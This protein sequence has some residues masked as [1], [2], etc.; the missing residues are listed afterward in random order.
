MSIV[1]S[2]SRES[3]LLSRLGSKGAIQSRGR[4]AH[5]EHTQTIG[6]VSKEGLSI[7][8]SSSRHT[9]TPLPPASPPIKRDIN[10]RRRM[11]PKMRWKKMLIYGVDP[12][13]RNRGRMPERRTL[14]LY[15]GS[16]APPPASMTCKH[17][18][19]NR[20][21]PA[22]EPEKTKTRALS[23][24]LSALDHLRKRAGINQRNRGPTAG[25]TY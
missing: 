4:E 17:S 22:I 12:M 9:R 19:K 15:P 23:G 20:T 7:V 25:F 8:A 18:F 10:C 11:P 14:P 6:H 1:R 24:S 5:S 2:T 21:G 16:R 13:A 3:T